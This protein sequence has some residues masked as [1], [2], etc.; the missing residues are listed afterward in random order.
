[1]IQSITNQ[2]KIDLSIKNLKIQ[3]NANFQQDKQNTDFAQIAYNQEMLM[4]YEHY[5]KESKER[6]LLK[7]LQSINQSCLPTKVIGD[8]ERI[9][10]VAINIIQN[11]IKFTFM[12]GITLTVNY[13]R[14]NSQIIFIV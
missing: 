5:E 8:R 4:D 2:I 10:Q 3:V 6:P 14:V 1:M 12:G 13:D 11:A 7:Y 9:M